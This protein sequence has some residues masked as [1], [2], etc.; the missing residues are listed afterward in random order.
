LDEW[1]ELRRLKF[2]Q[3]SVIP[4]DRRKTLGVH[5]GSVVWDYVT[6]EHLKRNYDLTGHRHSQREVLKTMPLS[7]RPWTC[8][9]ETP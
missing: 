2:L 7:K 1:K 8:Y 5:S 9:P 3:S 4:M 6:E